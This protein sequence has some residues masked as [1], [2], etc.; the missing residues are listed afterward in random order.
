MSR[1]QDTA[2]VLYQQNLINKIN[3]LAFFPLYLYFGVGVDFDFMVFF[4]RFTKKNQPYQPHGSEAPEG[5][6]AKQ[7]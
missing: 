7:N 1:I 6:F 5:C 3:D 2:C 4:L